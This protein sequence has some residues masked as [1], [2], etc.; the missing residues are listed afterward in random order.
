M[1]SAVAPVYTKVRERMFEQRNE[2][3]DMLERLTN[4]ILIDYKG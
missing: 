1:T 4:F 3:A 2:I